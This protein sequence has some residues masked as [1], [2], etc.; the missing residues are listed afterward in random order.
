M[1]RLD[2]RISQIFEGDDAGIEIE[3]NPAPVPNTMVA[4]LLLT[5][6]YEILSGNLVFEARGSDDEQ[7]QSDTE[8]DV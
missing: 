3:V 7:S 4:G 6:L 5:A 2:I 1:E 8:R